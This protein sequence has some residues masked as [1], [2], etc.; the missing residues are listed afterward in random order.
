M[1]YDVVG[2][3]PLAAQ[4]GAIRV[5]IAPHGVEVAR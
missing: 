2:M 1:V 5:T 3:V 4:H